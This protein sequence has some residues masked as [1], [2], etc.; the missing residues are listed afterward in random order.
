MCCSVVQCV[1]VCFGMSV[2]F[3]VLQCMSKIRESWYAYVFVMCLRVIVCLFVSVHIHGFRGRM[4]SAMS[5]I[6]TSHVTP[7]NES[8]HTSKWVMLHTCMSECIGV[9]WPIYVCDM[10]VAVCSGI[11]LFSTIIY[12][13][14]LCEEI[15][16]HV[17]HVAFV[18]VTWSMS[19]TW[20]SHVTRMSHVTHAL[21]NKSC[22]TCHI[23]VTHANESCHTNKSCHTRRIRVCDMIHSHLFVTWLIHLCTMTYLHVWEDP[24]KCVPWLI[25]TCDI[26]HTWNLSRETPGTPASFEKI[27]MWVPHVCA[28]THSHD[29]HGTYPSYNFVIWRTCNSFP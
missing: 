3:N 19:H 16:S 27:K 2:W 22:H 13:Y 6:W 4:D 20:M 12:S 10:S 8:C 17:S 21:P 29:S 18:C 15:H 5:Y 24:C 23:H 28:M 1:A 14:L 9:T 25:H 11:K 26:S 7:M